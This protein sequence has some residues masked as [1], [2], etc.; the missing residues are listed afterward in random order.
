MEGDGSLMFNIH[1]LQTVLYHKLPIKLFIYNN[2]G[3]YSIRVT[4]LNFFK[5]EYASGPNTGLSLP[6]FEKLIKAWGFP[7]VKIA[8]D[9]DL[10]KVKEVMNHKGPI[11]CELMIDPLQPMPPKW[12]AGVD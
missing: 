12:S 5:K 11:V 10:Y 2:N 3:Y 7:Y 9:K 8:S 6:N 1:E 4:H